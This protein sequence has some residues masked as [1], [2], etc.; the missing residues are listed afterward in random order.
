MTPEVAADGEQEAD[1]VLTQTARFMVHLRTHGLTYAIAM[2]IASEA[3]VFDT[4][5]ASASQCI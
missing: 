5:L 2:L 4:V 1:V 3:G